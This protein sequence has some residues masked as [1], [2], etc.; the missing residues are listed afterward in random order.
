MSCPSDTA[1]HRGADSFNSNIVKIK[2]YYKLTNIMSLAVVL[3]NETIEHSLTVSFFA[4]ALTLAVR[5][6]YL[7]SLLTLNSVFIDE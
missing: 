7:A 5:F 1:H 6:P 3:L 4:L 2:I